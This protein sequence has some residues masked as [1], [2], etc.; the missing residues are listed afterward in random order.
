MSTIDKND[1]AVVN[2]ASICHAAN[3]ALCESNDD[4]SQPTW[5]D[6]P[7]WQ[8]ASAINGVIFHLSGDHG[9]EESHESW[10]REKIFN[11]WVY[12]PEKDAEKKTH[13]CIMPF[14]KLPFEHQMKDHLF[15]SIVHAFKYKL[16]EAA[17][18][19]KLKA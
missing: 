15:A 19:G 2:I 1:I 7:D 10:M 12:G 5:E 9:P 8:K 3:K 18:S 16:Q 6:A 17:L 11:G 14:E 13:P 4:M